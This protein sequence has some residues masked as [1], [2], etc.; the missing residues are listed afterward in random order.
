[1]SA[2]GPSVTPP[3]PLRTADLVLEP[4]GPQHNDADHAAWSVSIEHIRAT[5]G[6]EP[7]DWGGDEWPYPMSSDDNRRDLERH[8]AE[9]AAGEAFAYT[10]LDAVSGDV[11]GCVYIDPDPTSEAD[12][13]CRSWVRVERAELDGVLH[14]SLRAWLASDAWP[15][16]T[17]RFPGRR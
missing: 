14:E 7:A 1:M 15:F 9:F 13:M 2:F 16:A 4:L 17:V 5:P 6:F 8:A 12:A 10:V 3:S 11:V